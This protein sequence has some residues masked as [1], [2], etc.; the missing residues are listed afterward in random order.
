MIGHISVTDLESEEEPSQ[1]D[2][3]LAV[4]YLENWIIS[5]RKGIDMMK[6]YK[7]MSGQKKHVNMTK[8]KNL[9]VMH[10]GI[11]TVSEFDKITE[12]KFQEHKLVI[13]SLLKECFSY[14]MFVVVRSCSDGIEI[15]TEF[16]NFIA[17][18]MIRRNSRRLIFINH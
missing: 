18:N 12:W 16:Y 3:M 11:G 2:S 13:A 7:I 5:S 10:V 17:L 6:F 14:I 9:Q 15:S 8:K 4:D 1:I